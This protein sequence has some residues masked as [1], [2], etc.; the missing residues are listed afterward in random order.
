MGKWATP[1]R[2]ALAER[3]PGSLAGDS[4]RNQAPNISFDVDSRSM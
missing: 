2:E 3:R 4:M 1:D